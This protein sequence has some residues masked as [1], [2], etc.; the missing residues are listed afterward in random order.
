MVLMAQINIS[1]NFFY[2]RF[3][4]ITSSIVEEGLDYCLK[5]IDI[6]EKLRYYLLN[7]FAEKLCKRKLSGLL[8]FYKE[9]SR[10]YIKENIEK[11]RLDYLLRQKK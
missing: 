1:V 4:I 5:K 2:F 6:K 8:M 11:K 10:K 3:K 7:N 9:L